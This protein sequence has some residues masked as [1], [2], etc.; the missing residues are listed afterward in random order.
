MFLLREPDAATVERFIAAQ[1]AL[2]FSYDEVCATRGA[3]LPA[4]YAHDRYGAVLGRG[5]RAY[6]RARAAVRA[7][8]VYPPRWVRVV[9]RE[10]PREGL[11]YA[12]L[13]RHFGFA[14]LNAC[15]VVYAF[16]EADADGARA[17]F[18]LGTLPGH[19]ERG[20]ERF[21]VA[22]D[23]ASGEVRYDVTAFSR[24]RRLWT[25]AG[26]PVLRALQKRFARDTC[27]AM[28]SLCADGAES[29]TAA[30]P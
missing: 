11:T 8:G 23:R 28:L 16:D 12:V 13:I 30:E 14:S 17:G 27:R 7:W 4:G 15:R 24:P 29:A 1:A 2:P 19:E 18:A 10:A 3:P 21:R 9:A 6:A 22:W 25:R 20:E 26:A 5:E